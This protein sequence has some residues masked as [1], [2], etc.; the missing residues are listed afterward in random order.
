MEGEGDMSSE[1]KAKVNLAVEY[2]AE[3][4]GVLMLFDAPLMLVSSTFASACIC[5]ASLFLSVPLQNR[6]FASSM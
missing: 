3:L 2:D 4:C 5:H 1:N 6:V